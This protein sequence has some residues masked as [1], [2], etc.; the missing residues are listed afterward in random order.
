MAEV[1]A[2]REATSVEARAK[3]LRAVS[4]AIDA[5]LANLFGEG[6]METPKVG[7]PGLAI[8]HLEP[9]KWKASAAADAA[10]S[11]RSA[12]GA[13]RPS[14][15][16]SPGAPPGAGEPSLGASSFG[17]QPPNA[18][19]PEGGP[20]PKALE[21]EEPVGAAAV[22][23]PPVP[24][25]AKGQRP[26]GWLMARLRGGRKGAANATPPPLQEQVG[27]AAVPEILGEASGMAPPPGP[28]VP[29]VP[30]EVPAAST[31]VA[32]ALPP[33]PPF[34][35]NWLQEDVAGLEPEAG[36]AA[37]LTAT[38]PSIPAPDA[39]EPDALVT[40]APEG[41]GPENAAPEMV[42]PESETSAAA[43][44]ETSEA[45]IPGGGAAPLPPS[46]PLPF[47]ALPPEALPPEPP[48]SEPE[49]PAP[50]ALDVAADGLENPAS[51]ASP[52]VEPPQAE[53]SSPATSSQDIS[54]Q[55]SPA[56]PEDA[57]PPEPRVG[58]A[59]QAPLQP[60]MPEV[61]RPAGSGVDLVLIWRAVAG[62]LVVLVMSLAGLVAYREWIWPRDGQYVAV[63]QKE[64]MPTVALRIDPASGVIFVRALGPEPPD[65][66]VYHLWLLAEGRAAVRLGRFTSAMVARSAA[67]SGL[68][69]SVLRRAKVRV[70]LEPA[71]EKEADAPQG[72]VMFAGQL[73]PE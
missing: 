12:S 16:P 25:I 33:P 37:A 71:D 73:M 52:A 20:P 59:P 60:E 49:A 21:V 5:D 57:A 27:A 40:P 63:L 39:A 26:P 53:G 68:D 34:L 29:P 50:E 64:P 62:V 10:G 44:A 9:P 47:E 3:A 55:D 32:A 24:R 13:E 46:A 2:I 56:E 54:S 35:P 48:P 4:E 38:P 1:G 8:P 22:A 23:G 51:A 45:E 42:G 6:P 28:D 30:A 43:P 61:T 69:P 7:S 72:E 18:A 67:L 17:L 31:P 15:R 66:Q 70:T 36:E 58:E 19:A 14:A 11:P 65:G 41:A